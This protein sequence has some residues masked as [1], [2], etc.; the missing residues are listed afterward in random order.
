MPPWGHARLCFCLNA[1]RVQEEIVTGQSIQ[2]RRAA[3]NVPFS[4]NRPLG[5]ADATRTAPHPGT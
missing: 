2:S 1:S 4:V 3:E 5:V